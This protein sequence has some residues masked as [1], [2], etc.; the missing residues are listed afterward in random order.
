MTAR[1]PSGDH[2]LGSTQRDIAADITDA[3]VFVSPGQPLQIFYRHL[4]SASGL[5]VGEDG[6]PIGRVFEALEDTVDL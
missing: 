6:A 1:D 2:A 4:R 5:G 3:P